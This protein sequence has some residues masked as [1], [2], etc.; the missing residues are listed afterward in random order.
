MGPVVK[1]L[2][3]HLNVRLVFSHML[4]MSCTVQYSII[5]ICYTETILENTSFHVIKEINTYTAMIVCYKKR[6]I[7]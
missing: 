5:N 3:P 7:R 2:N 4:S 1:E 6:I